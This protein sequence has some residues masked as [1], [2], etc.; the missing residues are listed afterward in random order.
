MVRIAL[1]LG[2]LCFFV[3][4]NAQEDK[5]LKAQIETLFK[6]VRAAERKALVAECMDT[7]TSSFLS[8]A[9]KDSVSA[10]FKE[11]QTMRMAPASDMRNF[12]E[13]V[14]RF[15]RAEEKENLYVWLGGVEKACFCQKTGVRIMSRIIWVIHVISL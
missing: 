10:V 9:E 5:L 4:G 3:V 14:N 8:G 2:L 12:A 15:C 7:W 11:L 13:C 1:L 6:D